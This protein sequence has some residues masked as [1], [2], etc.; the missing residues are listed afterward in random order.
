MGL[1]TLEELD[2][3]TYHGV[4]PEE[5]KIG[6]R[7]TVDITIEVDINK[8][9]ESDTIKDS[10]DYGEVYNI[11]KAVMTTQAKLLEYLAGQIIE[12]TYQKYPQ[13]ASIE[14]SVAKHNPP[15]GGVCKKAKVTL[16]K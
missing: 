6:N 1:I 10:I 16:K 2:F 11:I 15:V 14:V 9:T 5:N 7:Y 13:I 12:K 4:F 8:A 3:Y